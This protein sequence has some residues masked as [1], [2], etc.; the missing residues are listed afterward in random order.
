MPAASARASQAS[1]KR[2]TSRRKDPQSRDPRGVMFGGLINEDPTRKYVRANKA[3]RY[4]VEFYEWLGYSVETMRENGVR[5]AGARTAQD[6]EAVTWMDT[7]LMS[8]DIETWTEIDQFGADGKTGQAYA[9]II[10]DRIIDKNSL[11]VDDPMRGIF[12]SIPGTT[13]TKNVSRM[14]QK[15][16]DFESYA[17]ESAADSEQ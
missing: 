9:D 3:G 2:V 16:G 17:D 4:N 15:Q 12:K 8:I 13:V 14:Q 10:E 1:A 5:F 7:V 6:G 11:G